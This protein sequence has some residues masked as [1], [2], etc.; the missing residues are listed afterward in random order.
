MEFYMTG[1]TTGFVRLTLRLEGLC[2]FVAAIFAYI[3]LGYSWSTFTWFILTPDISFLGY[4]AGPRIGAMAY[5]FA[6]SYIGAVACLAIGFNISTPIIIC[7]GIIWCAHI[8]FDRALGYGLK[9]SAG[10]SYTH[11]GIIGRLAKSKSEI[12]IGRN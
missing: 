6:H 4:L 12:V 2:I 9:Y 10:F 3:K 5:N 7:A 1:E 8:G 11:L